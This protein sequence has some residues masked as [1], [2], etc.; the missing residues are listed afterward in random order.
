[1]HETEMHEAA[2]GT[3]G[4]VNTQQSVPPRCNSRARESAQ[5]WTSSFRVSVSVATARSIR[6]SHI[7]SVACA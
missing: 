4:R 2:C 1:M 7:W 3:I 5:L 6:Q